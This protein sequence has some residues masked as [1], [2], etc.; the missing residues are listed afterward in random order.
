MLPTLR[1]AQGVPGLYSGKASGCLDMSFFGRGVVDAVLLLR[2]TP[3]AST[4]WTSFLDSAFTAWCAD[5]AREM[6]ESPIFNR[7]AHM[8]NNH[9][10]FYD[11]TILSL[12]ALSPRH[13]SWLKVRTMLNPDCVGW[14][15]CVA[16]RLRDQVDAT[17]APVHELARP[18][19]AHYVWYSLLAH[20]QLFVAARNRG[21]RLVANT[22]ALR[23]HADW[24]IAREGEFVHMGNKVEEWLVY[25]PQALRIVARVTGDGRYERVACHALRELVRVGKDKDGR[26]IV[27]GDKFVGMGVWNLVFPSQVGGEDGECDVWRKGT[28]AVL[29]EKWEELELVW[30]WLVP[31][32]YVACAVVLVIVMRHMLPKRTGESFKRARRLGTKKVMKRNA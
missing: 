1:F 24:A 18:N 29:G 21:L 13:Q 10:L 32:V 5:L 28:F 20:A 14:E 6:L 2:R 19:L 30:P 26:D 8:R 9:G 4:H 22:S 16:G 25:A 7:E 17:G 15:F 3:E 27:W 11:L 12:T 31:A 23:R